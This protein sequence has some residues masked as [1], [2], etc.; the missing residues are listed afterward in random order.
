MWKGTGISI[1][2]GSARQSWPLYFEDQ[3]EPMTRYNQK[4]CK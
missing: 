2:F 4:V 3:N 1:S